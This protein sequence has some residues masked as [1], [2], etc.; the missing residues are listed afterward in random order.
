MAASSS[1][2]GAPSVS[3]DHVW[4]YLHANGW[5]KPTKLR[6][7]TGQNVVHLLRLTLEEQGGEIDELVYDSLLDWLKQEVQQAR[8]SS[9][10]IVEE[11]VAAWR[12]GVYAD[13]QVARRKRQ[14]E[15]SREMQEEHIKRKRAGPPMEL[16]PATTGGGSR[17]PS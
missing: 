16:R 3:F 9:N 5:L 13:L 10:A 4:G 17:P 14:E 8:A 2:E 1:W 12:A 11:E 7:L 15:A 6:T